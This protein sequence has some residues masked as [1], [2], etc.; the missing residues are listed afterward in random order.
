MGRE[1]TERATQRTTNELI[2]NFDSSLRYFEQADVFGEPEQYASHA[3]TISLRRE[4]GSASAALESDAFIDNVRHT[5]HW[6]DCDTR[7]SVLADQEMFRAELRR[8]ERIVTSL[9]STCIDSVTESTIDQIWRLIRFINITLDRKTLQPTKSKLVCASKAFHHLLPE[10]VVPIDRKYTGFFLLREPP[11]FQPP[12]EERTFRLAL[13]AFAAIAKATHPEQY[14]GRH[15]WHTSRTK[16]I[17]NA[18]VGFR[19]RFKR[20]GTGTF[21]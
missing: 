14:I 17:D 2:K 19:A 6:W 16:V 15:R 5:L 7:V 21:P 20:G 13:Q 4:L 11:M 1:E 9:E 3:R 8:C 12:H 18:I 10:L